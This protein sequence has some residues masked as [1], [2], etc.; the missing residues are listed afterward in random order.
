M[1]YYQMTLDA[2]HRQMASAEVFA[3]EQAEL[4]VREEECW[5]MFEISIDERIIAADSMWSTLQ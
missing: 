3:I 2:W 5:R 1:T 4:D